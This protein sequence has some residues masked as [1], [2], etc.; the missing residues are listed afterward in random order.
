MNKFC[1]VA[2]YKIN[3]KKSV[4]FIYTNNKLSVKERKRKENQFIVRSNTIKQLGI[5]L[6]KEVKDMYI[7]NYQDI[8]LKN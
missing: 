3:I 6:T 4:A 1:K 2:V 8:D 5:N 7:E